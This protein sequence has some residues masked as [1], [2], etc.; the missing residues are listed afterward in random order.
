M[1]TDMHAHMEVLL[2]PSDGRPHAA[3]G[4]YQA[5]PV[6]RSYLLFAAVAGVRATDYEDSELPPQ[7]M[8]YVRGL[9]AD[10]S[11]GTLAWYERDRGDAHHV[12]W[13]PLSDWLELTEWVLETWPERGAKCPPWYQDTRV[14]AFTDPWSEARIMPWGVYLFG[15]SIRGWHDHPDEYMSNIRGVRVVFWFDN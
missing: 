11:M 9:P 12:G 5:L 6:E 3:W 14:V 10:V 15:D 4:H 2:G 13:T 1:G 7:P 8:H